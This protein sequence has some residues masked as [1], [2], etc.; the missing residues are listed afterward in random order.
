MASTNKT[1]HYELSQYVGTDKPTY[2]TDYNGDMLAID[3]GIYNAQTKADSAYSFAGVAD[4]KAEDAQAT[5]NTAVTSASTANTKIGDL[6]N[7]TT[8][9]K[10]SIVNAINEDTA[11]ISQNTDDISKLNITS[12]TT[13][14][15]DSM[16]IS[17]GATL[18][19]GSTI[20]VACNSDG[21]IGKIY[22][23]IYSTTSTQGAY[24]VTISGTNLRPSTNIT[25]DNAGLYFL[26]SANQVIGQQISIRTDGTIVF[27]LYLGATGTNRSEFIP[28]LYF[29]K[30][31]G[32][33]PNP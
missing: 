27:N 7:L 15:N 33:Q 32:D 20:T 22:G 6:A 25:I 18:I 3:T 26:P 29:M 28:C 2:L 10:S 11:K 31:F 30:D 5:A 4:G 16:T 12:F 14:T 8:T 21:S 24:T 19:T 1:T 23:R 9:D 17:S 13:Y